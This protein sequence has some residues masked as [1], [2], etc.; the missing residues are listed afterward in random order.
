VKQ[1]RYRPTML[2]GQAVAVDTEITVIF[3]LDQQ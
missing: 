3:N 1:W 2:N